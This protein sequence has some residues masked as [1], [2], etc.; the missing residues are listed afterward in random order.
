[1]LKHGT[2]YCSIK[3]VYHIKIT[4]LILVS[5]SYKDNNTYPSKYII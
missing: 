3:Q 2:N 1:M 4:I 5:T